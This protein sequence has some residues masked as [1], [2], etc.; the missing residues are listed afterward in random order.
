MARGKG[1]GGYRAPANPAPVSGPG[2]LSQ[3]TDGRQP[4]VVPTGGAYGA[5]T[6]LR[7]Q[8]QSA[9]VP[10]QGPPQMPQGGPVGPPM[11]PQ[12]LA[13]PF[14]GTERPNEPGTAG[15]PIGPGPSGF[16]QMVADDPDA[17]IRV[18]MEKLMQ[19]GMTGAAMRLA[20]YLRRG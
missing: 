7:A 10:Q 17:L 5:A 16:P 9:P 4:V 18:H 2:A 20:A 8:Q 12:A 3:R 11:D 1:R 13:D 15:V 19:V 6:D 14:R